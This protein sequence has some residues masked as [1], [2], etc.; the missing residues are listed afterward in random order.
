[1]V[2]AR[3]VTVGLEDAG[4]GHILSLDRKKDSRVFEQK[5][6]NEDGAE[7]GKGAPKTKGEGPYP[8]VS[9]EG[10]DHVQNRN[11]HLVSC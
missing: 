4:A 8:M 2:G 9:R 5:P 10:I 7:L 6:S 11:R 3:F 1:M